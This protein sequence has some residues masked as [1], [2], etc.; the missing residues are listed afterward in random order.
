MRDRS[1]LM[2]RFAIIFLI[3]STAW[4]G[5]HRLF[6]ASLAAVASATAADISSSV[7]MRELNPILGRGA[8]GTRQAGIC[9]GISSGVVLAEWLF[10]RHHTDR[11]RA[12]AFANFGLAAA[13]AAVATRNYRLP[14]R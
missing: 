4:C 10:M 11:E 12:A 5:P 7:G 1:Y 13:H 9:V 8:F 2:K 3:C 6:R 14:D